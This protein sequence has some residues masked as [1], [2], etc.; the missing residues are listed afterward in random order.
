[1]AKKCKYLRENNL[2]APR[3][4]VGDLLYVSNNLTERIS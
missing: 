3:C 4:Q 1:M 2:C